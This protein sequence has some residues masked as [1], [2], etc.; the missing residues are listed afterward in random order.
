[1]N[2][3]FTHV[4][5]ADNMLHLLRN[6]WEKNWPEIHCAARGAIPSFVLARNPAPLSG[7]VPVFCYHMV[8]GPDL[9]SD[10]QY[11]LQNGYDSITAD[12]LV[13]HLNRDIRLDR[14]S[15]LLTFDD[16]SRNLHQVAFPLLQKYR[17]HAVAFAAPS[18]HDLAEA[19]NEKEHR[20]CTWAELSELSAS[21]VVDIQSH[22]L[23]HR[24]FS[25][26]PEPAPLC[27]ADADMNQIVAQKP[28]RS[29]REDLLLARET[30]EQKLGK[31]VRHLA[32][33]RYYGTDEAIRIG[34]EVGYSSFWWGVLPDRPT[35][36]PGDS[37]DRIVRISGEFLRRLPGSSRIPLLSILK[38]RYG[39]SLRHWAGRA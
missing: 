22:S 14:P 30:L 25:R 8:S 16:C 5:T 11:L 12:T 9:E 18:F 17:C 10:L 6:T 3:L 19:V 15:I 28:P 32:F 1:M 36:R 2:R 34:R 23:D 29:L 37:P 20:P 33:P 39:R 26:W 7:S 31:P 24:F 35:N 4:T 21:G 13:A 27:G 38:A